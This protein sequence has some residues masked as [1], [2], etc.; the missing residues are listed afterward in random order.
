M[1]WP[2]SCAETPNAATE[3]PWKFSTRKHEPLVRR[4]V[5]VAEH[6][7]LRDDLHIADA[8]ALEDGGGDFRA[9]GA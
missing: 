6:A 7:L 1:A 2:H 8:R 5:V 3:F 4:V 9:C